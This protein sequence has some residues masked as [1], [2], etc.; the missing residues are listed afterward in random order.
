M[1]TPNTYLHVEQFLLKKIH[2]NLLTPA[3][4][5]KGKNNNK[6]LEVGSRG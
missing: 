3:H 1:H 5:E 4:G 2:T 6:T